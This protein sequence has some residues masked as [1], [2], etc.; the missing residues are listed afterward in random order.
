[1][2]KRRGFLDTLADVGKNF[3]S[4]ELKKKLAAAAEK[5]KAAAGAVSAKVK[6]YEEPYASKT[7]EQLDEER[8]KKAAQ[9]A[10]KRFKDPNYHGY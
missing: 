2:D 10:A 9:E 5:A 7:Q 6:S 3:D 8:K 1:M 4:D